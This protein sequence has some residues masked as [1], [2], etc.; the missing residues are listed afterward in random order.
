MPAFPP[1]PHRF[2]TSLY[3]ARRLWRALLI[4]IFPAVLL[5]Q[6][7]TVFELPIGRAGHDFTLHQL[8]T[9]PDT[10]F[11][12]TPL[13]L[14]I[15]DPPEGGSEP[16]R[17]FVSTTQS[18]TNDYFITDES[19]PTFEST[20]PNRVGTATFFRRSFVTAPWFNSDQT[21]STNFFISLPE[22]RFGH[23]LMLY[24]ENTSSALT[25]SPVLSHSSVDASGNATVGSYGFF[26]AW[27]SIGPA[28]DASFYFL[29]DHD[30]G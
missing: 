18:L 21:P 8:R 28:S 2:L 14:E 10:G 13:T 15:V 4:G 9:P 20:A 19:S 12:S 25:L 1:R 24:T 26:E 30:Q 7:T 27:T 29:V 16:A 22:S 11:D 6:S 23:S 5:A 3:R 17:L